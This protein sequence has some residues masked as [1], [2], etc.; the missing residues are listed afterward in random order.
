MYWFYYIN[1]QCSSSYFALGSQEKQIFS[2]SLIHW[3]AS[4]NM[5]YINK[6]SQY[7]SFYCLSSTRSLQLH[8][9]CNSTT[10]LVPVKLTFISGISRAGPSK[11]PW[12]HIHQSNS[13]ES[14]NE[15]WKICILK[16][17]RHFHIEVDFLF[18]FIYLL[19]KLCK[20][21]K[22]FMHRNS[23]AFYLP[24]SHAYPPWQNTLP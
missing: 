6:C 8:L 24:F 5:Q 14:S 22:V 21:R 15:V 7:A 10:E 20:S 9:F 17:W 16:L 4:H 1:W 13:G 12:K 2:T 11:R 23:C 19:V 18:L 3:I